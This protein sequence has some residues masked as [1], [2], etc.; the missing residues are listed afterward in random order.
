[1]ESTH[2]ELHS[3]DGATIPLHR[4]ARSWATDLVHFGAQACQMLHTSAAASEPRLEN[5]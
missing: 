1:M 3:T 2:E 5:Q 4:A